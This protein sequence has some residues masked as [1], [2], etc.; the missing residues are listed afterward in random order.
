LWAPTLACLTSLHSLSRSPRVSTLDSTLFHLAFL[1]QTVFRKQHAHHAS[2]SRPLRVLLS[3][4][5]SSSTTTLSCIKDAGYHYGYQPKGS[6]SEKSKLIFHSMDNH[7]QDNNNDRA[8]SLQHQ[9]PKSPPRLSSSAK[10]LFLK[11]FQR[12]SN[13]AR[14]RM[15]KARPRSLFSSSVKPLL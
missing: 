2:L 5:T 12:H 10:A 9:P 3:L 6:Y 11:P 7:K 14:I 15:R 4:L 8:P 1:V 13:N